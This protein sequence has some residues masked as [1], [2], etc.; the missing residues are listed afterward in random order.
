[1]ITGKGLFCKYAILALIFIASSFSLLMGQQF[2]PKSIL[3]DTH[4]DTSFTIQNQ[5]SIYSI[6]DE[7]IRKEMRFTTREK[8]GACIGGGF[9][10]FPIGAGIGAAVNAVIT[11]PAEDELLAVLPGFFIGACVGV[12]LG[13][14]AMYEIVEH[15]E[16]KGAK[17]R[18]LKKQKSKDQSK[19]KE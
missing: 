19:D 9:L 8:I 14:K 4:P 5:D 2:S 1:M 6:S 12:V 13:G 7:E 10:G 16:K 17:E 15:T 18:L 3:D 11:K